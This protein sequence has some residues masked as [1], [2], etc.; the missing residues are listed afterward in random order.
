MQSL[1]EIV[2]P[3]GTGRPRFA[4]SARPAPLPPRMSRMAA[5]PSAR[6][7]PKKY[8]HRRSAGT[9]ASDRE[10]MQRRGVPRPRQIVFRNVGGVVAREAGVTEVRGIA[11]GRLEHP[12]EREVAE[13]VD[14]QVGADLLDAVARRDQLFLTGRVDAVIAGPGDRRRR[15]AEMHL[16]GTGLADELPQSPARGPTYD[17]V[18]HHHDLLSR[19]HPPHRVELDLHLRHAVG[20]GG[21]DERA[22]D[23][24]VADQRMLE[25]DTRLLGEP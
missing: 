2:N 19:E 25:L 3:G 9:G 8:T 6:P 23:V 12:V 20:L 13:R 10:G 4:I 15:H 24:M 1:A 5:E 22:A 18:V 14:A 16:R 17:R 21:M 11:A 7:G